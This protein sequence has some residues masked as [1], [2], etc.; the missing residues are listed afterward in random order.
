VLNRVL[1]IKG[2]SVA[3]A[4]N[5]IGKVEMEGGFI[6][7]IFRVE[8]PEFVLR[9]RCYGAVDFVQKIREAAQQA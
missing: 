9:L 1:P 8:A 3:V 2:A 4:L 5:K 6:T 7:K